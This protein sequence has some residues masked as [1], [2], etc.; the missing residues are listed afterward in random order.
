MQLYM[1]YVLMLV[2][3]VLTSLDVYVSIPVSARIEIDYLGLSAER[4]AVGVLVVD[5]GC[6]V[7]V[8][9]LAGE[10]VLSETSDPLLQTP[11]LLG[12]QQNLPLQLLVKEKRKKTSM[13]IR[14]RIVGNSMF[15]YFC[16]TLEN[17]SALF[18]EEFE[19][20]RLILTYSGLL[21]YCLYFVGLFC[22]MSFYMLCLHLPQCCK[23]L[24]LSE[25]N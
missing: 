24:N 15:P 14:F 4:L 19:R 25:L 5:L 18:F 17:E 1:I 13:M 23:A 3:H 9:D 20:N 7:L 2:E 11:D 6:L 22:L 16:K 8:A 21:F 10:G 12:L